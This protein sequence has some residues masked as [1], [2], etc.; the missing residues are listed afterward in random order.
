LGSSSRIS[1]GGDTWINRQSTG[2]IGIGG[3]TPGGTDGTLRVQNIY[4]GQI[5][6]DY[7]LIFKGLLN[8]AGLQVATGTPCA[9]SAGVGQ[10]CVT[11]INLPITEP[12]TNY[13]VL[14]CGVQGNNTVVSLNNFGNMTTTNFLM[15]VT[16]LG[17]GSGSAVGTISCLVVHP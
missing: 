15:H 3:V 9:L 4:G 12:D 16:N 6:Y 5:N 14:G 10:D 13:V 7:L 8:G 2:T 17:A 1:I 11:T